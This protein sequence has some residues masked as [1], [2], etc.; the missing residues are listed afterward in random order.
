MAQ[1]ETAQRVLVAAIGIP[2][3][4]L[5]VWAGGWIL[6]AALAAVAALAAAEFCRLATEKGSR[7]LLFVAAGGA[8]VFPLLAALS[9]GEGPGAAGFWPF[10]VLLA[11]GTLAASIWLR[12]VVG[13]PLAATTATIFAAI[14]TGGMLAHAVFIR[15][16]PGLDSALAGTALVFFPIL[17]TWSSDTFAYFA[18]RQFGKHKLIPG[19]SPGKTVEG[20]LGGMLGTVLVAIG[21]ML[22]MEGSGGPV[23]TLAEALLLGIGISV[24]A[25][26]G[27]LA[28]S[29][30]KRDAG[31]KDSG[32]LFP[33]HGGA[34]DRLDSLLFT[35]P[36][37]YWYF[38]AV[39]VA[40]R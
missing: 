35:I 23:L 28:E 27:D 9:P 8:A 17:L 20:A 4:V 30:L 16:L 38:A 7:P 12:G 24:I 10:L 1:S 14:Y 11:L 26:A 5:A 18:G 15:H 32:A 31:V 2:L 36:A 39:H 33:G 3:V 6:A 13:Q 40:L 25:Q 22:A 29:L 21:Y 34:L 37:A 19:V